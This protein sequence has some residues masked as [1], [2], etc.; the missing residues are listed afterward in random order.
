LVVVVLA[1]STRVLF[2]IMY[3]IGEDWDLV[4]AGLVALGTFLAPLL[5]IAV[6][7][8]S[9]R[10]ALI[11]GA[12]LMAGGLASARLVDPI[13]VA[14]GIAVVAASLGGVTLLVARSG[15]ASRLSPSGLVASI[16][17]GMAMDV[18]VRA[19]FGSWDL[20]WQSGIGSLFVVVV[21]AVGLIGMAVRIGRAEDFDAESGMTPVVWVGLGAYFMLQLLF[22]QNFAFLASQARV[23]PIVAVFAVLLADA[24]AIALVNLTYRRLRWRMTVLGA[25][26]VGMAWAVSLI[27]GIGAV[28][29]V[30][31]LQLTVTVLLAAA[32][33]RRR[34]E[35]PSR[36][37]IVLS[38][39]GGSF[40][41]LALVLVWL[42]HIDQPLPVP[43]QTVPAVAALIVTAVALRGTA[44]ASPARTGRGIV[45]IGAALAAGLPLGMLLSAPTI[46]EVPFA[47]RIDLVSYNVRGSV[48]IDGQLE[49]DR[50]V[51]EI[52]SSAPDLV[53]IQEAAR[54]WPIHGTMDLVSYLQR[55]L[56]MDFIFVPAAD[57]Q[58]GNAIFSRLPMTEIGRGLLPKDGSQERSYVLVQIDWG[59][60]PLFIAGTHTQTRS[61]SQVEALLDAVGNA[62]P[63]VVA[64]DMNIAP[65]DPEVA[66]FTSVGLIDVVG[67]T[68]D[69]CR[70]TSAEPTSACDRPDWVFVTPDVG[71]S[72]V[73]IGTGG[74]SDHLAIHVR[75]QP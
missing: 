40:L 23:D 46:E 52:L 11:V 4:L 70:T 38:V 16:V 22:L 51:E 30:I 74:A 32:V 67:A 47:G 13:P 28:V 26:V 69:E 64:G 57:G 6:P 21:L 56:A 44:P 20:A 3:E 25:V 50:I 66:L 33:R 71:I 36:R 60:V 53:V 39:A 48:G 58:F 12:A 27:E 5:V 59:D 43:R 54:G 73:R 7:S 10:T 41:F 31:A 42:L 65:D 19:A 37:R 35:L 34:A 75:L 63:L 29:A 62:S 15:V 68:G 1:Q 61:V 55:R 49:P 14:L 18:S 72:Q 9:A 24:G 8:M 2:P 17:L 45:V